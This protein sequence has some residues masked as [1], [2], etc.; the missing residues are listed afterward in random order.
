LPPTASSSIR[1]DDPY[2]ARRPLL[3]PALAQIRFEA[4]QLPSGK[5]ATIPIYTFEQLDQANTAS[6]KNKSRFLVETIGQ[7]ALPD[8]GRVAGNKGIIDYILDVQVS[9]LRTIGLRATPQDFGAPADW[10]RSDDAGYFGGD[11]QLAQNEKTYLQTDFNK[12][13]QSIQP[14]HRNLTQADAIEINQFEA[15]NGFEA[16]KR[17]NQG[18]VFL[19]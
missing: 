5:K 18:S 3:P 15:R 17:R 4:D 19:G 16:S 7:D 1:P 2:E 10:M 11:G 6:L 9:M 12:P 14:A 13:L 8:L